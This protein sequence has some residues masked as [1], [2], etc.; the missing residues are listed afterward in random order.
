MLLAIVRDPQTS[1]HR[2]RPLWLPAVLFLAFA[3]LI[4][5]LVIHVQHYGQGVVTASRNF[6][7]VLRMR[8]VIDDATDSPMRRLV[9]GAIWHGTQ[10]L[11]EDKRR[12]PVSYYGPGSGISLAIHNHPR[13]YVAEADE[14]S[15]R[16]GVVG[17]GAG[18][19]AALAQTGDTLRFYDINPAVIRMRRSTSTI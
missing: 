18:T 7:G 16:I 8:D 15:L 14:P 13:R 5:A 3:A 10:F 9:H 11:D 17:L 6:Y 12:W 1:L 2:C 19:V 4:A